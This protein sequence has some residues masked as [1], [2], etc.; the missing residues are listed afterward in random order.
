MVTNTLL[1]TAADV[2]RTFRCDYCDAAPG[3]PCVSRTGRTV[4]GR[5]SHAARFYAARESRLLPMPSGMAY[6]RLTRERPT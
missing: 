2:M 1:L 5:G 4:Y 6:L 3:R